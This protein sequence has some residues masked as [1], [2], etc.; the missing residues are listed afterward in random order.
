MALNMQDQVK[1]TEMASFGIFPLG[2]LP[3]SPQGIGS[4]FKDGVRVGKEFTTSIDIGNANVIANNPTMTRWGGGVLLSSNYTL[5]ISVAPRVNSNPATSP[6]DICNIPFNATQG[7]QPL[8][9][10]GPQ[11]QAATWAAICANGKPGIQFGWPQAIEF[12]ITGNQTTPVAILAFGYDWY[13]QP[14]QMRTNGIQGNGTLFSPIPRTNGASALTSNKAFFQLTRIYLMGGISTGASI[15]VRTS[16]C[17]GLPYA[18]DEVKGMP[19]QAFWQGGIDLGNV[20]ADIRYAD[21]TV[22]NN[23]T[24]DVRGTY[25]PSADPLEGSTN[26]LLFLYYVY[27]SDRKIDEFSEAGLPDW[28][29][30]DADTNFIVLPTVEAEQYGVNQYYTGT[31]A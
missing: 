20:N 17:Y 10:G 21:T 27:A 4:L 22:P 11:N 8:I 23:F 3:Q 13:G 14:M 5:N 24:A 28:S 9:A 6:I 2:N 19:I 15:S 31:P 29:N 12:K 25:A 30:R 16:P 1:E 7:N 26:R 18:L